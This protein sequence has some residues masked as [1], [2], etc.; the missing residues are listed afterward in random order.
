M[1]ID[2]IKANGSL[3]ILLQDYLGNTKVDF[4]TNN[5]VVTPGKNF[6]ASRVI[7]TASAVMSHMALGTNSTAPVTANTTLA[8][9]ISPTARAAVS[10][11]ATG[12]EIT[13]TSTFGPGVAS[14][15]LVEAGIFNASTAGTMLSRTTFNAVN[16]DVS[17]TLVVTWK[18]TIN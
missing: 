16:K 3:H 9:E 11:S 7:G 1:F 6:I 14:G 10:A 8:A 12:N 18:I 13:Y 2:D 4:R 5:L 15:T 17:D